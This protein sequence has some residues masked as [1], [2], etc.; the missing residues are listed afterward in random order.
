MR[1]HLDHKN[2][3]LCRS[4]IDSYLMY[5]RLRAEVGWSARR[6]RERTHRLQRDFPFRHAAR[7]RR[8][9]DCLT[10]KCPLLHSEVTLDENTGV[11]RCMR[12]TVHVLLGWVGHTSP[13]YDLSC[14]DERSISLRQAGL[15]DQGAWKTDGRLLAPWWWAAISLI[16]PSSLFDAIKKKHHD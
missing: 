11:R 15:T 12:A 4:L 6:R 13:G 2:H 5:R 10:L 16:N 14:F 8:K 7:R 9:E 3:F 1:R